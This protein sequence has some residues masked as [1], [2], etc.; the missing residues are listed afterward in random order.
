MMGIGRTQSGGNVLQDDGPSDVT[1]WFGDAGPFCGNGEEGIRVTHRLPQ[2]YHG[3]VS[4]AYRRR[5]VVDARSA[6]SAGSGGN[7]VGDYICRYT[8]VNH[9]T[10]GGVMTNIQSV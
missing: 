3:Q 9:G 6:I 1:A 7:A 8:A 5:Y 2:K 4:V 10:V